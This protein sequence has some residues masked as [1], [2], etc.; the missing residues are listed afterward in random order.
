M[1]SVTDAAACK[2][3]SADCGDC[4]A[5]QYPP[6]ATTTT[7]TPAAT[8]FSGAIAAGFRALAA[9]TRAAFN[10]PACVSA[11]SRERASAFC[12]S[13][14]RSLT[15]ANASASSCACCAARPAAD[16]SA[17]S[18]SAAS[19]WLSAV[20]CASGVAVNR[21]GGPRVMTFRKAVA[22]SGSAAPSDNALRAR[23]ACFRLSMSLLN[24]GAGHVMGI[25]AD[26][27]WNP[28]QNYR[29]LRRSTTSVERMLDLQKSSGLNACSVRVADYRRLPHDLWATLQL[30]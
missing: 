30:G 20:A 1:R 6:A 12:S 16:S 8:R 15:R 27:P 2:D 4:R 11:P 26:E 25:K 13:D 14:K 19:R 9:A 3:V 24:A 29:N 23:S 17:A 28:R 10:M 18:L 21:G 22:A 5:I 7:S